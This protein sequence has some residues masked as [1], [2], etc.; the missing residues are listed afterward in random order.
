LSTNKVGVVASAFDLL[1]AGHILMLKEAKSVC[2][3]LVVCLHVDP[4]LERD[5]KNRPIQNIV[6]RQI[7]LK[8]TKYVDEIIVYET[9]EQLMEIFKGNKFDVRIIGED[10]LGKD[11]TAKNFCQENDIEIY[12]AKRRHDYSS[13]G[14][15]N[16]VRNVR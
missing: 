3:Y 5:S 12:Y 15:V 9:E 4:S 2:D 13:S 6:E 1:H 8:G 7:Q 10:Y 11:F 16:R 14:L